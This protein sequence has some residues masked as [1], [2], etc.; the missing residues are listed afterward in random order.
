MFPIAGAIIG[1]LVLASV[2]SFAWPHFSHTPRP[3]P[4]TT[5]HDA[6]ARTDAGKNIEHVLGVFDAKNIESTAAASS[7]SVS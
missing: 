6:V 4:L 1:S 3:A 2:M 5:V 7:S